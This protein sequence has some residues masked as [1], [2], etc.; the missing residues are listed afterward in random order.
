MGG[1]GAV[2]NL[3]GSGIASVTRLSAGTYK[4]GLQ[5][6]YNRYLGGQ[7]G[8]VEAGGSPV[9]LSTGLSSGSVYEIEVVGT[10]PF[11]AVTFTLSSG[12]GIIQAVIQGVT[13]QVL[14]ATSDTATAA[15]LAA[16][17]N[18]DPVIN[19]LGAAVATAG[20]IV[21][22]A[23]SNPGNG[24]TTVALGT[25]FTVNHASTT[26]GNTVGSSTVPGIWQTVGVPIG[27]TPQP[28]V[29]FLANAAGAQSGYTTNTAGLLTPD[30]LTLEVLGDPNTT[31][32]NA[33][34]YMVVRFVSV[35]SGSAA[36][37]D[38]ESGSV[39]GLFFFFRNSSVKGKGE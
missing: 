32:N 29:A 3:K 23:N 21:F 27:V 25:G 12:A 20:A 9:A 11:G 15:A 13:K 10:A 5:D 28:G 34:P 18:A 35:A 14:W 26:G 8:I 7:G 2:G 36:A 1:T 33:N 17:I 31:I 39:V 4:I 38:P 24:I 16:A 37:T 6:S 19:K 22:T 30:G